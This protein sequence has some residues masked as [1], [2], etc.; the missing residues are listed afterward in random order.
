MSVCAHVCTCV[1][2]MSDKNAEKLPATK[3]SA[4]MRSSLS[5]CPE[6]EDES[7]LLLLRDLSLCYMLMPQTQ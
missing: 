5:I 3:A 7:L 1:P 4:V 6:G 2:Q